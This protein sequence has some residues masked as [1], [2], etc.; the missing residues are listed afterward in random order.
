M[1]VFAYGQWIWDLYYVTWLKDSGAVLLARFINQEETLG[2]DDGDVGIKNSFT[3]RE[4]SPPWFLRCIF[5]KEGLTES[6]NCA[7]FGLTP[8]LP[9]KILTP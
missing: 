7:K 8:I 9:E 5:S 1:C 3:S 6:R 4:G 2:A